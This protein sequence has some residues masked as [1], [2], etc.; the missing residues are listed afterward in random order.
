MKIHLLNDIFSAVIIG[1]CFISVGVFANTD[2]EFDGTLIAD[3]CVITTDTAE[4]IVDFRNVPSKTFI[5]HN[6]TAPESFSFHLT[7][8]DLSL[9]QTV[10]VTFF[11]NEDDAQPGNFAVAGDAKGIAIALENADGEAI[12]PD[13]V[14]SPIALS[15]GDT[16]LKY[17]AY[18]Q[19]TDFS[20][21]TEGDFLSH[22]TFS[23]EYE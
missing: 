16:L 12:K 1:F 9:G 18:I 21:V 22:V 19:A 23:L 13:Q 11:G 17:K 7:E 2:V 20:K 4:Q 15:E 5:K 3:P 8:C 14:L 6:R 10:K